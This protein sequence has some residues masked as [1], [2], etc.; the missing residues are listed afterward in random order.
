MADS[1]RNRN[2]D[3]S[4]Q[5][6]SRTGSIDENRGNR[7]LPDNDRNSDESISTSGDT[8]NPK[9]SKTSVRKEDKERRENSDK[10]R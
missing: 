9:Y 2:S 5:N 8:S 1:N 10:S 3:K 6:V 4:Q 7:K